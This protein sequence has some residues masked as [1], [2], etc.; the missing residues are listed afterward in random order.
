MYG[1]EMNNLELPIPPGYKRLNKY[2]SEDRGTPLKAQELLKI[3]HEIADQIQAKHKS[4]QAF[5]S[6]L[7]MNNIF[8]SDTVVPD[9]L[10][11]YLPDYNYNSNKKIPELQTNDI[12][13]FGHI[14]REILTYPKLYPMKRIQT[15]IS[16]N[17]S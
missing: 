3:L 7:T 9:T 1:S 17:S 12:Q 8:I 5:G 4:K 11:F 10:S 2:L 16:I 6:I 15:N 14:L 13:Q